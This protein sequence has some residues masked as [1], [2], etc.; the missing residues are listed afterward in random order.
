MQGN[1]PLMKNL[2]K[3]VEINHPDLILFVGEALTGNDAVDQLK[4][5]NRCLVG[6]INNINYLIIIV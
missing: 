1:E 3:L 5:F 6:K 2:A 4:E